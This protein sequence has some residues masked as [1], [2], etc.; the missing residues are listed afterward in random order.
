[1]NTLK[2]SLM[3]GW[4]GCRCDPHLSYG[5][6]RDSRGPL[7]S[8]VLAH[9]MS[10]DVA[11]GFAEMFEAAKEVMALLEKHGKAI[12]PHLCDTDAGQRLRA[13]LAMVDQTVKDNSSESRKS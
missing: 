11:L 5:L 7:D 4:A 1:M 10:H 13:A 8:I 12:W 3:H 6:V 2:V 9:G